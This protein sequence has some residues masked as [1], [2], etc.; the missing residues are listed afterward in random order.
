MMATA[1]VVAQANRAVATAGGRPA[2]ATAL[3]NG[4]KTAVMMVIWN[5]EFAQS[6]IAQ[7]RSSG[8]SR[9]RRS[10]ARL[11]V[12]TSSARPIRAAASRRRRSAAFLAEEVLLVERGERRL[13][14]STV[15]RADD[16]TRTSAESSSR[17]PWSTTARSVA[18]CAQRQPLPE[19]LEDRLLLGEQPRERRVQVLERRPPSAASPARRPRS[20]ARAAARRRA[21]CRP[22]R[23]SPRRGRA[24]ARMPLFAKR[25]LD[26]VGEHVGGNLLE[27]H[28]R[29]GLVERTRG[30]IILSI[31]LGSEPAKT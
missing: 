29:T 24:P 11:M 31:R 5:A 10:S 12:R 20:R 3:K 18:R 9:P 14:A 6:Y 2:A 1:I 4:G 23:R 25:A 28:D 26:E 21:G 22:G 8:R 13:D 19:R 15:R 30:P 16:A 27:P 7:A 17:P